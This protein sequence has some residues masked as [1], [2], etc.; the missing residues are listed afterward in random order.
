MAWLHREC[1]ATVQLLVKVFS[2]DIMA[3]HHVPG[4]E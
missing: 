4:G 1:F 2:V 3:A